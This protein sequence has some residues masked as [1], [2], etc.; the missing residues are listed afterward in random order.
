MATNSA[1]NKAN[2]IAHESLSFY[3]EALRKDEA[4]KRRDRSDSTQSS[5]ISKL[6]EKPP[7]EQK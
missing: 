5:S 4:Q 1:I 3:R 7:R 6:R 2:R